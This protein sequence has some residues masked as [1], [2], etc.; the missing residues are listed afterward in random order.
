MRSIGF[1]FGQIVP[2]TMINIPK[3]GYLH[4]HRNKY[5]NALTKKTWPA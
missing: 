2:G 5:D 4:M 1:A 3:I